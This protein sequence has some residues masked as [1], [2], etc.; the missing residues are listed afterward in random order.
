[1]KSQD[2]FI[3]REKAWQEQQIKD[4]KSRMA[5]IKKRLQYAQDAIQKEIDAQWD[6]FSNGQKTTRSEAMKRASEMDVKAFARKAK[7]YVKE[8]DFSP[9]ANKELKL[10]NLTMRVNRLE[11]LKA[12]IGLELIATFDDLD[13][14]F[15]NELTKAGL[16]ELQRQASILDMTIS[17]SDYGKRVEQVLNS[18]FK[19][20]GFATFSDNLWMYQAE[21][22][23][24]LDK[25]LVRSVT[26]GRNPK[27]LAPELAKYLTQEGRENTKFNT[28][29]L[30]VTETTRVQTGIQKQSYLDM[31]FEEFVFIS[32]PTACRICLPLNDKTFR[33]DDMSPGLNCAPMHPFCRCSTAPYVDRQ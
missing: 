24:D 9:T 23:S 7:K 11:L 8:K 1:M 15:S 3:K 25:L 29:R 10:Y 19:A 32:E 27:Q 22:K 17:K 2:Y 16:K 33:V 21:L 31:E 12:N 6:S 30:M 26:M 28:Q 14:Y 4:D 13:K 20:E 5:E 18:S